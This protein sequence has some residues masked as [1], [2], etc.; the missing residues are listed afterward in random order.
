MLVE[1]YALSYHTALL[2]EVQALLMAH[3]VH[4]RQI[5]RNLLKNAPLH[6]LLSDVAVQHHHDL[7]IASVSHLCWI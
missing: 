2:N 3:T 6:P 4:N 7:Y 5:C 1:L